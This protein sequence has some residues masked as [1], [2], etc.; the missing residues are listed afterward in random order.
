MFKIQ[1][2]TFDLDE[3]RAMLDGEELGDCDFKF[4]VIHD[5]FEGGSY[6]ISVYADN[7]YSVRRVASLFDID[8]DMIESIITDDDG[9]PIDVTLSFEERAVLRRVTRDTPAV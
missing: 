1:I 4:V 2:A 9:V 7:M 5:G 8:I 3:T 6:E